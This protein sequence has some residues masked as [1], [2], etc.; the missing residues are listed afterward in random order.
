ME[1]TSG[2]EPLDME[3]TSGVETLDM[4]VTSGVETL[5]MEVTSGVETL[6]MEVTSGVEDLEIVKVDSGNHKKIDNPDKGCQSVD[7]KHE[8]VWLAMVILLNRKRKIIKENV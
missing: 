5:D 7:S 8:W 2:V 3:I 6:D 1:V 4:E